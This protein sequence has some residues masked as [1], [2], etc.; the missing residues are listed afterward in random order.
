MPRAYECLNPGLPWPLWPW[1]H[2]W[3]TQKNNFKYDVKISLLSNSVTLTSDKQHFAY[4]V[5][6][7]IVI[8]KIV[9]F[10]FYYLS[11]HNLD[12]KDPSFIGKID[13]QLQICFSEWNTQVQGLLPDYELNITFTLKT[14][15]NS[16]YT[17]W[18]NWKKNMGK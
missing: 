16:T 18:S 12:S 6:I 17:N 10:L 1:R 13:V 4:N 9:I 15:Y 3:T 8:L 11:F 14:F 5:L 7:K 2:L